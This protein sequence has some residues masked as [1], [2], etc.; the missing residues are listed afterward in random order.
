MLHIFCPV[1]ESSL[2]RHD[3][4]RQESNGCEAAIKELPFILDGSGA[5]AFV[6]AYRSFQVILLQGVGVMARDNEDGGKE[7]TLAPTSPALCIVRLLLKFE[8]N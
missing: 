2:E 3:L 1:A 7:H 5:L 4:Q 8:E 6:N